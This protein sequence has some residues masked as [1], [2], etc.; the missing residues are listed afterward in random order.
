MK[1]IEIKSL[2]GQKILRHLK[3][4]TKGELSCKWGEHILSF[5]NDLG[6]GI[7]R[8]ASF[9]WGI[10]GMN[11][12]VQFTDDMSIILHARQEPPVEFIYITEGNLQ[13]GIEDEEHLKVDRYQNVIISQKKGSA[14]HLIFPKKIRTRVNFISVLKKE[15]SGKKNNNLATLDKTLLTLFNDPKPQISFTHIGNYNLKIADEVQYLCRTQPSGIAHTLSLEGRVY[16]ILAMQFT[17]YSNF[18]QELSIPESL[19]K[20]DIK[21]IYDLSEYI[22]GNISQ[23][24]TVTDLSEESGLSPKKLQLGFK[25]LYSQS[26]NEYIR[27]HQL[28]IARDQLR[29]TDLSV[30]E[31]VYKI[32]FKSRSYFSKIFTERYGILPTEYRKKLK[33]VR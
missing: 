17:E 1:K 26:V 28:E 5:N 30:S 16:L 27:R 15:Y 19:S 25:V 3:K 12:D 4:C 21:E 29:N 11:F 13:L 14:K 18:E 2:E 24:L 9:E 32:G 6:N 20:E 7:I 31:I 22:N 33:R 10:S 23:A 8:Y